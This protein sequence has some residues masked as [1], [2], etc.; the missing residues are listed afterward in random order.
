[1]VHGFAHFHCSR[2]GS[3]ISRFIRRL[4]Q[5][6]LMC[7]QP[8]WNYKVSDSYCYPK[9]TWSCILNYSP[10]TQLKFPIERSTLVFGGLLQCWEFH[11]LTLLHHKDYGRNIGL[12]VKNSCFNALG[13]NTNTF[14]DSKTQLSYVKWISEEFCHCH[15][16]T[17]RYVEKTSC[18][19]K[20]LHNIWIRGYFYSKLRKEGPKYQLAFNN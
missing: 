15:W 6:Q 8:H 19:F 3:V 20:S 14:A 12:S 9:Y 13:R 16:S 18:N 11:H 2:L 4:Q 1:M 7:P 5:G 17:S 10:S